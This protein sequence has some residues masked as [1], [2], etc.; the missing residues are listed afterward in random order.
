MTQIDV[1]CNIVL[2]VYNAKGVSPMTK[3]TNDKSPIATCANCGRLAQLGQPIP[4]VA[5]D[6]TPSEIAICTDCI[7]H[8]IPVQPSDFFT[9]ESTG[10]RVRWQTGTCDECGD[11]HIDTLTMQPGGITEEDY[12]VWLC[13]Y[14]AARLQRDEAITQV[15]LQ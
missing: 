6:G 11:E 1:Q 14:C 12:P 7:D 4:V 15:L 10:Q 13:A 5:E 8:C 3:E 9:L 2:Y